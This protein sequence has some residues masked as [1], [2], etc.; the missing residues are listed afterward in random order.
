LII[1]TRQAIRNILQHSSELA[2]LLAIIA[3][4]ARA[5][6]RNE[7]AIRDCGIKRVL[8]KPAEGTNCQA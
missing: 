8:T 1:R 6:R 2:V 4:T 7:Q 5:V 3:V